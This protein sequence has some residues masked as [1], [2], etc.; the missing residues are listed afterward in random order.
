MKFEEELVNTIGFVSFI[1]AFEKAGVGDDFFSNEINYI[2]FDISLWVSTACF[3][4]ILLRIIS[5]DNNN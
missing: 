5:L 1:V 3:N 4:I 2:F